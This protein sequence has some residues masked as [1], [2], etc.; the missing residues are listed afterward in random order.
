MVVCRRRASS[1]MSHSLAASSHRPM[2][3]FIF[4]VSFHGFVD[5]VWVQGEA[6]PN[7]ARIVD[8][9]GGNIASLFD[10]LKVVRCVA[11]EEFV[12]YNTAI[13]SLVH[14][15]MLIDFTRLYSSVTRIRRRLASIHTLYVYP[16]LCDMMRI[17]R[18]GRCLAAIEN[19]KISR[20]CFEEQSGMDAAAQEDSGAH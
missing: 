18:R 19:I 6:S 12:I 8:A 9:V 10:T 16:V 20:L 15:S 11:D 1:V 5:Q 2:L 13:C 4:N 3:V 7:I 14:T 17:V